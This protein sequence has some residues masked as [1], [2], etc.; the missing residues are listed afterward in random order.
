MNRVLMNFP[1]SRNLWIVRR[2][3]RNKDIGKTLGIDK[4]QVLLIKHRL[5]IGLPKSWERNRLTTSPTRPC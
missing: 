4:K 1:K 2:T 5:A 3:A